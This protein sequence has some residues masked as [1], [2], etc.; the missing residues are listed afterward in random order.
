MTW[1]VSE[2]HHILGSI[3]CHLFIFSLCLFIIY[4]FIYLLRVSYDVIRDAG[5]S[6]L[7]LRAFH[8]SI[9]EAEGP[10]L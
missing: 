2:S 6:L 10:I 1:V 5:L 7:T 3:C 4:L 8:V 9:R